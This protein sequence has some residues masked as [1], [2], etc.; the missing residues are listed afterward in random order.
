MR[1]AIV[2][3]AVRAEDAVLAVHASATWALP[4]P[5]AGLTDSHEALDDAVHGQ[6][7][8]LAVSDTEPLQAAA[9]AD[10]ADAESE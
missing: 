4:E 10:T 5:L 8:P 1:P 3:V 7:E 9:V 2:A 6:A